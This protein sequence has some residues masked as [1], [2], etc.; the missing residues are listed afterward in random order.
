[1]GSNE[2]RVLLFEGYY[3]QLIQSIGIFFE[4]I[5]ALYS[6]TN[7]VAFVLPLSESRHL[8]ASTAASIGGKWTVRRSRAVLH[9]RKVR[10]KHRQRVIKGMICVSCTPCISR[11]CSEKTYLKVYSHLY[12]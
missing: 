7:L 2:T 4:P 9:D 10:L 11:A 8:V 5:H 12:S 3:S 1:M 6:N